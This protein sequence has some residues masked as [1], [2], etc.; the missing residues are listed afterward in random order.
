[1]FPP[2]PNDPRMVVSGQ[3][4]DWPYGRGAYV[5]G[6]G[7]FI[8][9]YGE[10]DHLR[11][12]SM[13]VG[14]VLNDVFDRLQQ[15][16]E[17]F[18]AIEGIRFATSKTYGYV[19]SSPR[20]LG[21]AMRASVHVKLPKLTRS[22]QDTTSAQA[23]CRPLGLQVRG[24]FGRGT[25]AGA[26]GTVDVSP[27]KMIFIQEAEVLANLYKGVAKLVEAETRPFSPHM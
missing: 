16:L 19:T 4:Q 2:A 6:D 21:T 3:A 9:W 24:V 14:T 23:L 15:A 26:D 11:L 1:M 20:N 27:S 17:K 5:S 13:K 8:V 22:G 7:Q 10:Q 18:E 25:A 12:M